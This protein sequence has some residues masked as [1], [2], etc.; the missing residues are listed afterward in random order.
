MSYNDFLD[1]ISNGCTM[2][3]NALISISNSLIHN[4][5]FITLIGLSLFVSLLY[6]FMNNYVFNLSIKFRNK[7]DDFIDSERRYKLYH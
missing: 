4:Y 2:F 7:S 3:Y 6:L 1:L 5:I